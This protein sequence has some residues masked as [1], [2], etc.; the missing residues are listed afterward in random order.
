MKK[1]KDTRSRR[2]Y[3]GIVASR[4]IVL[5]NLGHTLRMFNRST[6]P[7]ATITIGTISW[8]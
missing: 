1:K 4:P 7:Y 2:V 8:T 5:V 6:C 3:F